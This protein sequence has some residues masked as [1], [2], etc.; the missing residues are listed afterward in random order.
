M[1]SAEGGDVVSIGEVMIRLAPEQ[2]VR[3]EN[4]R[5]LNVELGGTECNVVVG[6]SGLGRRCAWISKLAD[7]ELGRMVHRRIMETG[8]DVSRV[9]WAEA[10]AGTYF[11][12]FGMKPRPSKIIYDRKGSAASLMDPGEIDWDFLTSFKLVHLSGITP[13]LSSSCLGVVSEAISRARESGKL[14]SF[15]VNFRSRL[16]T[17][18][19]ARRTLEDLVRG[20]DVLFITRDDAM[21]VFGCGGNPEE[22][23]R[24]LAGRYNADVTVLTLGPEGAVAYQSGRFYA[25]SGHE[26]EEID[27]IGAG[28]AF[29]AGFLH[30]YL[31]GDI[32]GAVEMGSA[33]AALKH[34]VKGDFLNTTEDEVMDVVRGRGSG[35]RR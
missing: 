7:N 2:G 11:V 15:D 1:R 17:A 22:M 31:D 18:G 32:Q 28:D 9:T 26:V 8:V 16:W 25:D 35:I 23:L 21:A 6:L 30:G 12:E 13:A 14:V 3:L 4:A 19:R 29:D 10:R 33:M 24:D 34:T 27:R 5:S 20:C